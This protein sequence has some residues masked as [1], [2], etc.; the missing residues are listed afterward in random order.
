MSL[1]GLVVLL[2]IA[3][4]PLWI[5]AVV[6][7]AKR[8]DPAF[9]FVALIVAAF[10]MLV[11]SLFV[12]HGL[13]LSVLTSALAYGLVLETNYLKALAIA[14]IQLVLTWLIVVLFAAAWIGP[15]LVRV[16]HV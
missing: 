5:G 4:V 1:L 10:F 13:L 12:R 15:R 11:L 8:S 7:G 3:L 16:F 2:V 9:C 6:V 14:A